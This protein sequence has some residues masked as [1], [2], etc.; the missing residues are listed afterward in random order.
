VSRWEESP[1]WVPP[2]ADALAEALPRLQQEP[3]NPRLQELIRALAVALA[4]GEP[5]ISLAAPAP[6]GIDPLHWPEGHRSALQASALGRPP[7][8]PLVLESDRI[9]WR[10][11]WEQRQGVLD[12]LL[13]RARSAPPSTPTAAAEIL[14]GLD[15][16]QRRAVEAVARHRLVL[17]QGGPGTGKT[18]T[19]ARMLEWLEQ[20]QSG[21]RIHLAAPTG[22]AAAR[23]RTATGARHPC[24]TLH[25]LLE[26]RGESFARNRH[27]PLDL[28]LLVVDEVSMVDQALMAA[29]L[30]ALPQACQLVLVGDPAQLPPVAPGALLPELQRPRLREALGEAAITLRTVH[31]NAGAI[32]EVAD[33]LRG[34][35]GEEGTDPLGAIRERLDRLR[36]ADNLVWRECPADGLP[37]EL[38][39]A[40]EVHRRRLAERA[41]AC[42]SGDREAERALLAERDRLLVLTPRRR[43]RWGVEAIHRA[44]LGSAVL[45][46][47]LRWPPG[48]P[49][50]CCR[51][52]PDLGLANGDVG[53]V[54]AVDPE[55]G[56]PRLLFG[57]SEASG[58]E[59]GIR[60][61]PA[62]IAGSLEPAL[63]LT[64]HKAQGSE[65]EAVIVLLNGD[66][67]QDPRLLYTALTRAR[68]RALLF[69]TSTNQAGG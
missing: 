29:L 65:A 44:L 16:E 54:L 62:Q 36:A 30:A 15:P 35:I 27:N 33:L 21:S 67:P 42:R 8:G 45:A 50:L 19:V 58:E 40:L 20:Q 18:S 61:H 2:L 23:L 51:N 60:I 7:L 10:R 32:A 38:L 49:A 22:K 37:S 68:D 4:R 43:G 28:D 46:D 69:T 39:M 9:V 13:R 52:L 17:L 26:S 41:R 24:T 3:A 59:P 1:A 56:E 55:D 63:A 34:V 25:R 48:T 5:E 66:E 64:V 12:D 14:R 53:I 57:P 6:P 31:R 47:P 11:W